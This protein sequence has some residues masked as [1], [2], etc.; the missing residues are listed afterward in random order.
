MAHGGEEFTFGNR[1]GFCSNFCLSQLFGL[2]LYFCLQG[3]GVIL[4]LFLNYMIVSFVI[5]KGCLVFLFENGK[6]TIKLPLLDFELFLNGMGGL[7]A[8]KCLAA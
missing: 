8:A 1:G 4:L 3:F 5:F 2:N 7:C 6:F